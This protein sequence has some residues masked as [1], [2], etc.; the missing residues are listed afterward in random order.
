MQ[1]TA[2]LIELP[3]L[4]RVIERSPL[5]VVPATPVVDAIALMS[6][7]Q[8][9]SGAA[10]M[11]D[12]I[13]LSQDQTSCVLV[14][15]DLRLVGV[16]TER[17][18][19]RLAAAGMNFS[20]VAIAQVMTKPVV[21]LKQS[22]AESAFFALSL[23]L[24]HQIRYLPILNER[25]QLLGIV[26]LTTLLQAFD[27][28]KTFGANAA[29]QQH[30]AAR[31]VEQQL[32][33]L[34]QTK[35]ESQLALEEVQIAQE[36][37]RQQ[38]EELASIHQALEMERQRYQ[39]L[40]EF[41]PDGYLVTDMGGKIQ[42]ANRAAATL[43]SVRQE[44]LVDKPLAIFVAQSDRKTFWT[45]LTQVQQRQDWEFYLHP[46]EGIPFPA[47]IS[48]TSMHDPQGQ[49]VGLRWLIRDIT[50]Y[51]QMEQSLQAA[52]DNLERLVAERT[53]EL[54][55]ANALLQKEIRDR[56]LAE[57]WI[58]FQAN[59]LSQVS[60][61]VVAMDNDHRVTYWNQAAEQ[62]YGIKASEIIGRQL[63]ESYQYRWLNAED[64][65]AAYDAL[66][67]TGSWQGENIH[68][69]KSGEKIYV[70]SSV[71]ILKD[72][73]GAAIGLLAVIRNI[74]NRK[75]AE[76]VLRQYER[77]V[78][79]T[80][81]GVALVDCN[82]TYRLVNQT[83]LLNHNKRY[84]EIVGHRIDELLGA[85][86][87]TTVIKPYLDRSLGG[88]TIRYESW[89]NYATV[90]PRFVSVTYAPYVEVDGTISGVVVNTRDLSELK[91]A[92][93]ALRQ[94]E[95]RFRQLA[96]NIDAVFWM[97]TQDQYQPIYIS[98]AC[99]RI[100]GRSCSDLYKN[101]YLFLDSLHPED[102]ERVRAVVQTPENGYEIEFRILRPDGAI[103]WLRNRSFPIRNELGEIYRY[104]GIAEDITER[105]QA[106]QTIREQATLLDVAT[107]AIF[108]RD[109][110]NQIL[111]WNKAAEQVYGWQTEEA[112]GKNANELLYEE[113]SSQIETA[114]QQ[115]AD[116]GSWQGELHKVTKSGKEIIVASRWTLVLDEAG[117]PKSILTVDTDITEKKQLEA[118]FLRAQRLESI[119]TLASGIAHDLNNILTPILMTAQLLQLQFPDAD[120]WTME[121]LQTQE[122]NAKRGAAVVK[123]VLS[124]TRGIEGEHKILQLRHLLFEI[125]QIV[126]QTFPKSIEFFT[127]IPQ[128]LWTISGDTTQLHQVLMNLV[129]NARDAM[130]NGGSLSVCAENLFVDENYARMN[131]DARVG[132]YVVVTVVD[133]GTGIPAKVLERIFDPFFTT[134][135]IGKGTGLGLSTAMG[136]VKSHGGFINVS[137]TV[138]RTQFQVFLP[139]VEATATMPAPDLEMPKGHGE[140]ILV[141]DDEASIREITQT[142]LEAHGYKV[143]AVSDGIEAIAHYAQHKKEISLVVMD[144]MMPSMDGLTA[145]HILQKMNPAANII[146]VSGLVVSPDK[147]A[148][149]AEV[150][151]KAF[152]AKPYT[153]RELLNSING[154][155]S[156]Q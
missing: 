59:I 34:S 31:P 27:P 151:V 145:I 55:Q 105:M 23:C 58:N 20:G 6:Q 138:G 80:P 3:A 7:A 70:E 116:S 8:G 127:D 100:W 21:T 47:A 87:F 108:V 60:D 110:D 41:A 107:D 63:E 24:Q 68:V 38:N 146:A 57:K 42:Q 89:F 95:E 143:S 44:H 91:R 90:G 2:H 103:R 154:V 25:E 56:V 113:I 106:E 11:L 92:E 125:R 109:L 150:G 5:T 71:S 10:P 64:E 12:S 32:T 86:I 124:F 48:V 97:T 29:L 111:F 40:F 52:T 137:S 148:Y 85:D 99:D 82:Y 122:T 72:N 62:Q 39:D 50:D 22:E 101:V 13:L 84:E 133:T 104:A 73:S 120:K 123:Q 140:L 129:V 49:V 118:Q 16:F 132:S 69:K 135:E 4:D 112:L 121:L 75:Q 119:G 53:V 153:A 9:S 37:L 94:S 102:L 51:K 19:V 83:Y 88:E 28:V 43:L 117:Q 114:L 54:S 147:V 77:V 45:R 141:V 36:E 126:K 17:D 1:P 144:W 130:P 74:T 35:Q 67:A 131:L 128:E 79:A 46:R 61:A 33:E 76:E 155:L 142:T 26:T 18:V 136:I 115:V 96:E 14:V 78:S 98:P 156:A 139:A 81:D 66:A 15:K 152:L 93:E 134:K 149:A 65:Q 30:L